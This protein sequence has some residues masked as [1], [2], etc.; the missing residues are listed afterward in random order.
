MVKIETSTLPTGVQSYQPVKSLVLI[1]LRK[2]KPKHQ[3][4]NHQTQK[5]ETY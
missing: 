1:N 3:S 2:G 4:T 5:M